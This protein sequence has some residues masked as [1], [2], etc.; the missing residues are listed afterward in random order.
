VTA[1]SQ[2][3]VAACVLAE[4]FAS[5]YAPYLDALDTWISTGSLHSA[6]PEFFIRFVPGESE[7][8][9]NSTLFWTDALELVR[10]PDGSIAAPKLLQRHAEEWFNA[11]LAVYGMQ[12]KNKID[13]HDGL[14][15]A[16]IF[17]PPF[18]QE[19]AAA[20]QNFFVEWRLNINNNDKND[21]LQK[22]GPPSRAAS[23][24][25]ETEGLG[26][27]QIPYL[28]DCGPEEEACD[29]L[30]DHA[31]ESGNQDGWRA[32]VLTQE[33]TAATAHAKSSQSIGLP[34]REDL[35]DLP[36]L[37]SSPLHLPEAAAA[38]SI[39]VLAT[40]PAV[41]RESKTESRPMDDAMRAAARARV[42]H[43][44]IV[45][46]RECVGAD[47][48][49]GVASSNGSARRFDG[50]GGLGLLV[51]TG[52]RNGAVPTAAEQ[53]TR[54]TQEEDRG[55]ELHR[56][57]HTFH[58]ID[59][60]SSMI[61][62]ELDG[63]DAVFRRRAVVEVNKHLHHRPGPPFPADPADWTTA[64]PLHSVFERCLLLPLNARASQSSAESCAA[65]LHAGLLPQLTAL[66]GVLT[67]TLPALQ[68]EVSL[69]LTSAS[70]PRGIEGLSAIELSAS[71]Q[72][73]LWSR[74]APSV[75]Q[76]AIASVAVDIR[77][78]T[79]LDTMLSGPSGD[80]LESLATPPPF[81]LRALSVSSLARVSLTTHLAFPV[82][83]VADQSFLA[84][85]AD[86]MTLLLQLVWV[87]RSLCG[88]RQARWN[89]PVGRVAD[90]GALHAQQALH[91][92]MLHLVKSL[93]QHVATHL[94][95]ACA[96]LERGISPCSS[97]EAIRRQCHTYGISLGRRC[98]VAHTGA[99]PGKELNTLFVSMLDCCLHYCILMR[100]ERVLSRAMGDGVPKTTA[101]AAESAMDGEG[102]PM[103]RIET[104]ERLRQV[105]MA[106]ESVENN[107]DKRRDSFV[108]FL[109]D[110]SG[111]AGA[112]S[113]EARSLLAAIDASGWYARRHGLA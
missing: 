79:P 96:E 58:E 103:M 7:N 62:A 11:G 25:N 59:A 32:G 18:S 64:P 50:V 77:P 112:H 45:E 88:A 105:R 4:M 70:T 17:R 36:S 26:Q 52:T 28:L 19:F 98:V 89:V 14:H 67:M 61:S 113:A 111:E 46:T 53:Q 69:L 76:G 75:L 72:S 84:V 55:G 3:G 6:P 38:S 34:Q 68:P 8:S 90:G 60:W 85:H 39:D 20:V 21:N 1:P 86:V 24:E 83:L 23:G 66:C 47:F 35:P 48:W 93:H 82:A 109:V 31:Q 41:L 104:A 12:M 87:E 42:E 56:S 37:A 65:V 101:A 74:D 2:G 80:T 16:T 63:C 49:G 106:L 54:L 9:S 29:D 97:L 94:N 100:Q 107:W 57:S 51:S 110:A 43:V 33:W 44:R 27:I 71:L 92:E 22:A 40:V 91:H 108:N 95:V 30:D 78:A 5:T 81:P 15:K 102:D 13:R 99:R 73:S 10:L